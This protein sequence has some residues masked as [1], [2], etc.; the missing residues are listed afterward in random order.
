MNT[1][2]WYLDRTNRKEL[3]N[4]YMFSHPLEIRP[5]IN[6][7]VLKEMTLRDSYNMAY[8]KMSSIIDEMLSMEP[9]V[10]ENK[11]Y[12]VLFIHESCKGDLLN[13]EEC[14][15]VYLDEIKKIETIKNPATYSYVFTPRK[16]AVGFL[17]ADTTQTQR[18]ILNL[19]TQFLYEITF[20]GYEEE[21]TDEER[22]KLNKVIEDIKNGSA[23]TE[24]AKKVFS[25][26]L[27]EIRKGSTPEEKEKILWKEKKS[28]EEEKIYKQI[29]SQICEL[30]NMRVRSEIKDIKKSLEQNNNTKK[31]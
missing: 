30:D 31:K 14:C 22:K 18:S 11:N 26:L 1:V 4:Y 23:T 6:D 3:L 24:P 13:D 27:E 16:E 2:Q 10:P 7:G 28:Q 9:R 21:K 17:V 19:L 29:M 8:R 12:G 15:L 5:G 25:N 20:F